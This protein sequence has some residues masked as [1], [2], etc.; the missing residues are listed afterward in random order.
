MTRMI[1]KKTNRTGDGA[2]ASPRGQTG[3]IYP[4]H[5]DLP[6][7]LLSNQPQPMNSTGSALNQ[8]RLCRLAMSIYLVRKHT[9]DFGDAIF[10]KLSPEPTNRS[11]CTTSKVCTTSASTQTPARHVPRFAS[12]TFLQIPGTTPSPSLPENFFP[13]DLKGEFR[14]AWWSTALPIEGGWS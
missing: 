11:A 9:T 14:S 10:S 6:T 13:H 1:S 7:V 3:Q 12:T 2:Q 4:Q 8:N 5:P